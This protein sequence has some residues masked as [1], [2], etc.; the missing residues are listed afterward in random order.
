M[1]QKKKKKNPIQRTISSFHDILQ[2]LRIYLFSPYATFFH[3]NVVQKINPRTH[4]NPRVK[5]THTKSSTIIQ[6]SERKALFTE[7]NSQGST[8]ND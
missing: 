5:I 6:G 2:C 3:I 1:P 8:Q 7:L 4:L